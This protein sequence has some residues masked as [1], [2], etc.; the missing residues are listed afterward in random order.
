MAR[1]LD[2]SPKLFAFLLLL[3][4]SS[5][6]MQGP[7]RVALARECQSQ[8]SRF[9]GPCV[10]DGNCKNVCETEGFTGGK[11][12]GVRRRCFCSKIC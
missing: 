8:S 3:V 1:I 2:L 5:T 10:R 12:L 11:C 9:L 7:V 6:E 4:I